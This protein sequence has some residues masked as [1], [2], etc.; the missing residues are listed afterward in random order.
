MSGSLS[1]PLRLY[2]ASTSPAR[3][4]TLRAVGIEPIA[5]APGVD[6]E[7]AVGLCVEALEGFAPAYGDAF[8]A[9]LARRLGLPDGLAPDVL[10]PLV[11][12]L[13]GLLQ[14]SRV[15][16]TTFFRDL[17]TAARGD[18]EPAR[19]RFLDLAAFDAW[20]E[21]WSALG[22]DPD[23]MERVNPVYVPRNHLLQDALDAAT[24]GDLEP[25]ETMLALVG[26]PFVARPGREAYAE[27]GP[28]EGFVT[29]CGT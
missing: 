23:A 13:L 6:E 22:P 16:L 12:E 7:A 5:L 8:S 26:D 4:A 18:A 3:L 9:H 19:G 11:E 28:D 21:R 20:R 2:L 1:A 14:G 27:A 25:F 10:N 17:A 29:F 15:D 24:A